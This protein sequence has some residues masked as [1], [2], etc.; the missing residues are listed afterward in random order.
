MTI[1]EC[2]RWAKARLPADSAHLE[3]HLLLEHVS[4]LGRTTLYAWPER[5]LEQVTIRQFQS[6]VQQR[7]EG[8]PIAYLLGQREFY[9]LTL[10][11]DERVLIPRPETEL[12]VDVALEH[13][14]E[15]Q[16]KVLDLGTGSGAIALA[17]ASQRPDWSI[18]A[19]DQSDDAL[20]VAKVNKENL[21]VQNVEFYRSD[22]FASIPPTRFDLI[23][24][25]PPYVEPDSEFLQ[26]GDVRFEPINAL[27]APNHGLA[28]LLAIIEAAPSYL[29]AGGF[30][31]LEHG[32]QQA[33]QLRECLTELGYR[34]AVTH[35]DLQGLDRVTGAQWP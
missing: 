29:K 34:G 1:G 18:C 4:G 24:S 35:C 3:A 10:R 20:A 19:T 25:N 26:Q 8:T 2:L 31:W 27:V 7:C 21:G 13:T 30:I 14:L 6:L 17:L 33:E 15:S 16:A 32:Y 28:D 23:V 22:W 5:E 9:G 11:V 12:L